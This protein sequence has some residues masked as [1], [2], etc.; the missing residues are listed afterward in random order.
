[1]CQILF[2][3]GLVISE[4]HLSFDEMKAYEVGWDM[5]SLQVQSGPFYSK[6]QGVHT[7]NMQLG[8]HTYSKGMMFRGTYPKGCILLYGFTSEV[9]PTSH[10]DIVVENEI[11]VGFPG[12]EVDIIINSPCVAYTLV[13][14]E[15]SFN[16]AF[17]NYFST[18]FTEY[19]SAH[20]LL[21]EYSRGEAL[22]ELFKTQLEALSKLES[23]AMT[24][25]DYEKLET[26]YLNILF[27]Y[28]Q[29]QEKEVQRMKF[30][31][32]KVRRYFD[33][34]I[35]DYIS[36]TD[37]SKA[38]NISERQLYNA[39]KK[40]YGITPKKYLLTRRFNAIYQEL[41]YATAIDTTI[42]DIVA[43]YGFTHMSHFTKEFKRLF[44][45]IPSELL[46]QE[47]V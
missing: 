40:T 43:K 26:A 39:F 2:P 20:K 8:I 36:I 46:A 3:V 9:L 14:E 33:E 31:I 18:S 42:S 25:E 23:D 5:Q 28:L 15:K 30:D 12:H 16:K 10:N 32:S 7:P 29:N 17:Y 27:S 44:H 41:K 22:L 35:G 21:V 4:Q 34:N 24:A 19:M 38:L 13:V 6:I 1:M 37:V 45:K 11:L 47:V